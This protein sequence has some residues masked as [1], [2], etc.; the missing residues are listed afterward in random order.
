MQGLFRDLG[1]F[2]RQYPYLQ[3]LEKDLAGNIT[4]DYNYKNELLPDL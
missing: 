1:G 2:Y 4:L 3:D